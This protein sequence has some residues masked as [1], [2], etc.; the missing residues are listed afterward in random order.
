MDAHD[1]I[2]IGISIA[3]LL[4][5]LLAIPARVT[6]GVHTMFEGMKEWV[7]QRLEKFKAD[8]KTDMKD[9]YRRISDVE[10][11]QARMQGAHDALTRQT[12]TDRADAKHARIP[13]VAGP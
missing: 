11:E 2:L 3:S 5:T 1:W 10:R 8:V 9:I 7:D 12:D 13:D 4:V 6:S